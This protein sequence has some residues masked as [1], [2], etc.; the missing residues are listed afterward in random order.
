MTDPKPLSL[1]DHVTLT[2]NALENFAAA[3]NHVKAKVK[4]EAAKK[5]KRAQQ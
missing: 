3:Q 4:R 5:E 1:R 2:A